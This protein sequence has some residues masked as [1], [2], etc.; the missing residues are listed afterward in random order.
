M[1]RGRWRREATALSVVL[2]C[3]AMISAM[4]GTSA[5]PS[6]AQAPSTPQHEAHAHDDDVGSTPQ[7]LAER[8]RLLDLG[9]AGLAAGD[10]DGARR[11]FEQAASMAHMAEIELGILR[12]QMQA[13]EYRQAL[14]F[15]AH[16]AG[17]HT[18]DARGAAFYAWL[19]NL[20][21]QVSVAEQTLKQAEDRA[22]RQAILREV[23]QCWQTGAYLASGDM[24]K[25]PVRMAPFA[26]GAPVGPDARTVAT[27]LLLADGRHAVAPRAVLP[28]DGVIWLRNGLGQT[29]R[30]NMVL[31]AETSTKA[32]EAQALALL[33]FNEPLP[34]AAGEIVPAHDP[35]AGS[36]A[37]AV[38][39]PLD[40]T[41][42]PAWPLMRAGFLGSMPAASSKANLRRL[43]V[44]LPGQGPRGG[45]VYDQ[46]G[47]LL[48][49]AWR[50]DVDNMIPINALRQWFGDQFG[51]QAS[52]ARPAQVS[53]D[54]LYERAMKTALQVLVAAP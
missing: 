31:P 15:A 21:G 19:L 27:A 13:G 40:Q 46:A 44:S 51:A 4:A 50:G 29:V 10:T 3:G 53:A 16:T 2:T 17:V 49:V 43:G 6:H 22:P 7:S 47:R 9:E 39:Y 41:G 8:R 20:G 12:T 32:G 11:A 35:F 42:Q 38:D 45:P 18:D 33:T 37:F 48:G 26:S 1:R 36:P 5:S 28:P 54:E 34:V 52:E 25:P 24:L 14:A 30:A 23:R